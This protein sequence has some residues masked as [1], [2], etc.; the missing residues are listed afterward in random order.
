MAPTHNKFTARKRSLGQGNIFSSVCQE[1]CSQVGYL[2]RYTRQAGTRL[3]Q[4]H[5]PGQVHP[6]AAPPPQAG[7]PPQTGTL[8]PPGRYIPPRQVHPLDRYTP[9]AGT[10]PRAVH[11][12]KYGQQVGGTHPTGMH[13]C[14]RIY[15]IQYKP[16]KVYFLL[17]QTP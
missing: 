14:S 4:V 2:G 3:R 10:P 5:P 17:S 16:I 13:S 12:G 15:S 1:F 7:T 9:R 6:R 8:P 11:A